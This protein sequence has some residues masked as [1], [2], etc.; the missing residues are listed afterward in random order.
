MFITAIVAVLSL[1]LNI[2]LPIDGVY[3][4]II[5]LIVVIILVFLLIV[6]ADHVRKRGLF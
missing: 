6:A 1:V 3:F 4:V 2:S 5:P